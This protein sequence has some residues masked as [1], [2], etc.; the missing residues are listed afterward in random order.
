MPTMTA[1]K[2]A[3][4]GV[5]LGCFALG[6]VSGLL[7]WVVRT[8]SEIGRVEHSWGSSW[9]TS[10]SLVIAGLVVGLMATFMYGLTCSVANRKPEPLRSL[11]IGFVSCIFTLVVVSVLD[12]FEISI[13][14]F[15]SLPSA[16]ALLMPSAA[17]LHL[18]EG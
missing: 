7:V 5:G 11:T 16:A 3:L 1:R 6:Y 14:A 8:I 17:Q 15:F 13:V 18:S 4:K 10:L 12:S 2:L 9:P